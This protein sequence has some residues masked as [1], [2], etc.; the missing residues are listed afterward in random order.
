MV[1]KVPWQWKI[2]LIPSPAGKC[3]PPDLL[4]EVICNVRLFVSFLHFLFFFIAHFV[5]PFCHLSPD[6]VWSN[7][8]QTKKKWKN[9]NSPRCPFRPKRSIKINSIQRMVVPKVWSNL[10]FF[11]QVSMSSPKICKNIYHI[12]KAQK[13]QLG[14]IF[15]EY[16]FCDRGPVKSKG[17]TPVSQTPSVFPTSTLPF[18]IQRFYI[19]KPPKGLL[20]FA[21]FSSSHLPKWAVLQWSVQCAEMCRR[22]LATSKY[23]GN[24]F[25]HHH[26]F[27]GGLCFDFCMSVAYWWRRVLF[28]LLSFFLL[29]LSP[30]LP[31]GSFGITFCVPIF[32]RSC[33]KRW[34][35]CIAFVA[36]SRLNGVNLD[37]TKSLNPGLH[38]N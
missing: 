11:W 18:C 22:G 27:L 30:L 26:L 4:N 8:K 38:R 10:V 37:P 5:V 24:D 21:E 36:Y 3:T 20:R 35:I 17:L 16:V 33:A 12:T 6:Y 14:A 9:S 31:S 13:S 15:C 7:R 32:I 34:T 25:V 19:V 2:T 23:F 28:F 1:R 29:G